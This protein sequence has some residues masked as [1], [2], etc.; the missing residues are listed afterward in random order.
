MVS[1]L[2]RRVARLERAQAPAFV[3]LGDLVLMSYGHP[4]PAGKIYGGPVV[5]L[6]ERP[7]GEREAGDGTVR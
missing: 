2:R 3:T 6:L 7:A 1:A 5:E 4:L